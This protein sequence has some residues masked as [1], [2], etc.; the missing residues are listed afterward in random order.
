MTGL[1]HENDATLCAFTDGTLDTGERDRVEAHMA[2]C[3]A[4]RQKAAEYQVIVSSVRE[5]AACETAVFERSA[6]R[7]PGPLERALALSRPA[8]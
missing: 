3:R 2:A 1:R 8:S 7:S 6:A 4:C 5:Q